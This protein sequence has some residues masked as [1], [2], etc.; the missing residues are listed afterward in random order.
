ME[1]NQYNLYSYSAGDMQSACDDKILVDLQRLK[2]IKEYREVDEFVTKVFG[3][4]RDQKFI[5]YPND[6]KVIIMKQENKIAVGAL[7]GVRQ[8][9]GLSWKLVA[10]KDED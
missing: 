5:D 4:V 9:F 7:Q 2:N 6:I 1:F 8:I 10:N 3:E